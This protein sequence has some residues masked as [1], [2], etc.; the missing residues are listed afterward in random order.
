MSYE[1][2]GLDSKVIWFAGGLTEA[3]PVSISLLSELE[4]FMISIREAAAIE[5]DLLLIYYGRITFL[6][7]D[8]KYLSAVTGDTCSR[9]YRG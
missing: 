8:L 5:E 7:I 2:A 1:H 4:G 6:V 9:S 3:E